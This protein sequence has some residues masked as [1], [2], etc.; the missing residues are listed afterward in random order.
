MAEDLLLLGVRDVEGLAQRD[1]EEMYVMLCRLDGR[2]HAP[3][4]RE[5]FAGL[6][7]QARRRI[8]NADACLLT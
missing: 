6:V 8:E 5:R 3:R 4:L 1:P 2:R 7:E